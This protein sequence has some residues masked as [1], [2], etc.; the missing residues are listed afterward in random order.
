[1]SNLNLMNEMDKVRARCSDLGWV[2]RHQQEEDW[3][4]MGEKDYYKRAL[5]SVRK[6]WGGYT[7][8]FPA[9]HDLPDA[10]VYVKEGGGLQARGIFVV[11]DKLN[12]D[13]NYLPH[14]KISER[15]VG[16]LYYMMSLF[17]AK[18]VL[19]ISYKDRDVFIETNRI[20]EMS[21][22]MDITKD[23]EIY[24]PK[25]E[26]TLLLKQERANEG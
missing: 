17:P 24:V 9:M 12:E 15:C 14:F 13:W 3:A 22:R 4:A 23:F 18:T 2:R 20:W 1:M 7:I 5:E 6:V 10:S 26:L 8:P 25:E 11:F 19:L 16:S 21:M